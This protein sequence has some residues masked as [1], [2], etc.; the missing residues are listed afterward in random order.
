[1]AATLTQIDTDFV[2]QN[3]SN[4]DQG[5]RGEIENT[6]YYLG[7]A[8]WVYQQANINKVEQ[9]QALLQDDVNKTSIV[10]AKGQQLLAQI[11]LS[12]SLR[13]DVPAMFA[14]LMDSNKQCS[15]LSGDRQS[16]VD[17][18]FSEFELDY[19]KGDLLAQDKLTMIQQFQMQEAKIEKTQPNVASEQVS[20]SATKQNMVAM[21]GDGVNDA[22]VL[23]QADVSVA[24][25]SGS[26]L[27]HS[28]ADIILLGS[29][30][31]G[32]ELLHS[33]AS[34]S[35]SIIK[36]NMAWAIGY[37]LLA[38]PLAASGILTPWMAAIGMSLS[39]LLVVLNARRI[40][41]LK[42]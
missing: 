34:K 14:Y 2:A 3:I 41:S 37:N 26:Q 12:D 23:S 21:V 19:A 42:N 7:K 10:L 20:K 24:L 17:H 11:F 1:L 16:V 15:V 36:Q 39:S 33:V 27:S 6:V 18:Q 22:P 40:G 4:H 9:Q 30:L 31:S 13:S 8:S 38:L 5:V 35:Q 29:R 28:Q 25:A 32:I